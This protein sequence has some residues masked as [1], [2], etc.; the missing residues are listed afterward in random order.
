MSLTESLTSAVLPSSVPEICKKA[1]RRIARLDDL[2]ALHLS[3]SG[4]GDDVARDVLRELN[5]TWSMS[6][7]DQR[8]IPRS[9]PVVILANHPTGILDGLLL[10]TLL[11][12][13]RRDVKVLGNRLLASFPDSQ[14]L[15]I[16][17]DLTDPKNASARNAGALRSSLDHLESGGVLV[18]FPAGEVAA[19]TLPWQPAV[20][21]EWSARIARLLRIAAGRLTKLVVVPAHISGQNSEAFHAASLISESLRLAML[22]RELLNKRGTR[23]PVR[24]GNAIPGSKVTDFR[25]DRDAIE[26]LRWRTDL[27]ASHQ[28]WQPATRTPS[29]KRA[30][31]SKTIIAASDPDAMAYEVARLGSDQ[32]LAQADGLTAYLA[33]AGQI[34]AVMSEIARLREVSF[35]AAGEGTGRECD[36]DQF[37]AHYQH[38]F[39]WDA[40]R[41]AIAGAYRLAVTGHVLRSRGLGG[42]YSATLFSYSDEF[43]NRMG[44]SIE[45]GRSFVAP[46]YQRGFAPLLLLWKGISKF[47]LRH[48]ECKVLFGPVSISADYQA[49]SRE[50]MV[51]FLERRVDWKELLR[52][53]AP[54][55]PFA[56]RAV[57]PNAPPATLDFDELSSLVS[58][59]EPDGKGVPVLLRQYLKLGG[60][61]LSFSVDAQFSHALDGLIVVDLRRTE[62]RLLER[63]FG[64]AET[65]QLLDSS[66]E[67]YA[68]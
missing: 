44:P 66:K 38:L 57:I 18:I 35:R 50:L 12:E 11:R 1:L 60:E 19:R 68:A 17:I 59:L 56:V 5:V 40:D 32:K 55:S 33:T 46:E 24:I 64:K 29:G 36:R 51:S 34:P 6:P 49:L 65:A 27:L 61:L 28:R 67:A 54:K 58:D 22:P 21:R 63:Y 26:Y 47:V 14:N 39:L 48:P 20:D 2:E 42:L 41:R 15:L 53:V 4:A 30:R 31:T 43:L 3:T 10:L 37:D 52:Y 13:V 23:I 16:P 25:T 7:V 8:R 45:L 62:R 9:G